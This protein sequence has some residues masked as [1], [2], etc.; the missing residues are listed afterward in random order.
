MS[1][2]DSLFMNQLI[3]GTFFVGRF[4]WPFWGKVTCILCLGEFG[5]P[6]VDRLTRRQRVK[7]NLIQRQVQ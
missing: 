3:F 2:V 1:E 5:L 7:L 4:C 6:F